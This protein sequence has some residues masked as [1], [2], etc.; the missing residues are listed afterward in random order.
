MADNLW[1]IPAL[2]LLGFLLNGL[3]GK[4]LGKGFVSWVGPGVVGASFVLAVLAFLAMLQAPG[5]SISQGL[6]TWIHAGNFTLNAGLTV[7]RLSGLYILIVTGVGFLIHVY[8]IGYMHEEDGYHRFFA[9]LNLFIFFMLVLVLGNSF[10]L[11]FV[12]WEGV[13][14][15]SYLLIGYYFDRPPAASAAKKAF[16]VNRIGDWGFILATLI[17]FS[18]FGTLDLATVTAQAATK[19]NAGGALVTVLTL[20]LFLGA[21]GK[22]AQIPLYVWL[23]DAMEGP[24]PVSALIHA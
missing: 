3:L 2:P 14:L 6:Y 16:I 21:T 8:S 12:G 17:V 18:V 19:L 7:D 24:T 20:L 15:C 4:R 13:G 9:Y 5:E 10:L 23:P 11:L 1:W 22:S